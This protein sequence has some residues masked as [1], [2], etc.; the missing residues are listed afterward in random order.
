MRPQTDDLD[1]LE[2][3]QDLVDKAVLDVD[4]PGVGA[5]HI[6]DE[7]FVGWWVLKGIVLKDLQQYFGFWPQ[8][9]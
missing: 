2:I 7:F 9:G 8:P 6:P 1:G 5:R 4:A 3:L